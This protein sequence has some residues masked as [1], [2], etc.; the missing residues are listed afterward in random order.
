MTQI[1]RRI[2]SVVA[3]DDGEFTIFPQPVRKFRAVPASKFRAAN[4][5]NPDRVTRMTPYN[6]GCSTLSGLVPLTLPRVSL[7]EEQVAA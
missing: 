6:G 3:D 7:L 5:N 4:D 1:A 2:A